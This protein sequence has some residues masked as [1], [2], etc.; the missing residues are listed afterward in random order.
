M[1]SLTPS[2]LKSSIHK[3]HQILRNASTPKAWKV[4]SMGTNFRRKALSPNKDLLHFS[5]TV[6]RA[7]ANKRGRP[8]VT[9]QKNG[10][11]NDNLAS[12]IL[13]QSADRQSEAHAP[14]SL[15]WPWPAPEAENKSLILISLPAEDPWVLSMSQHTRGESWFLAKGLCLILAL[16][17]KVVFLVY[18]E[19][20]FF[21][22]L[23]LWH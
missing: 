2:C 14:C 16:C 19:R 4:T 11:P 5:A 18:N 1:F 13:T 17:L 8:T 9:C 20:S 12:S 10:L 15:Y 3:S 22:V 21:V 23:S 6:N 7:L